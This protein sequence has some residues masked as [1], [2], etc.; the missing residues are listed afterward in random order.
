MA[1]AV[2]LCE[3]KGVVWVANKLSLV[4]RLLAV[5]L[6]RKVVRRL[7]VV[8]LMM[9]RNDLLAKR[10]VRGARRGERRLEELAV[11]RLVAGVLLRERRA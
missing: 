11:S 1:A 2:V 6:S 5:S 10:A 4:L 3:R 7:R 9:L 8:N